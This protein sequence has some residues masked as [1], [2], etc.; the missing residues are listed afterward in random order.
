LIIERGEQSEE[1]GEEL[2]EKGEEEDF[3]LFSSSY[4]CL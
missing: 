4:V 1:V 2:R 3:V